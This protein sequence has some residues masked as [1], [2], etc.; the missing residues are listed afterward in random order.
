MDVIEVLA[1]GALM[2]TFIIAGIGTT[3]VCWRYWL[4]P[5][6]ELNGCLDK[7]RSALSHNREESRKRAYML[8]AD[9]V[10]HDESLGRD[11]KAELKD[12]LAGIDAEYNE[13]VAKLDN[14][15]R[16]AKKRSG[17]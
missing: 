12:R 9:S 1:V 5:Y 4:S 14:A 13:A 16:A 2:L 10:A 15:G 8:F 7:R 17:R 6:S 3:F 11:S